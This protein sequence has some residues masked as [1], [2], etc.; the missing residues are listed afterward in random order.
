MVLVAQSVRAL[1]CG[2]KGRG[3]EPHLAP[4]MNKTY[5][6]VI[7]SLTE[8]QIFVFG[9]NTQGRHGK[10]GALKA[11]E[12]FGAIYGQAEGL[13]GQSYA[14]ITKDISSYPYKSNDIKNIVSQIGILYEKATEMSD[15]EFY[16]CYSGKGLNLNG[17]S[18]DEMAIM[19]SHFHIP[20][21]IVFEDEFYE[22][23]LIYKAKQLEFSEKM[24]K[25]RDKNTL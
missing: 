14:I 17:Y 19:F 15:Y 2:T 8:K 16:V 7:E 23:I 4:K 6:G 25:L 24:T 10:G 13:Q 5:K 11:K 21:N 20:E 1:V 3:F 9:S 18:S 22:L 12:K